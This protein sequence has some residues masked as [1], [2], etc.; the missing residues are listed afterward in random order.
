V[1]RHGGSIR[2]LDR[3]GGGTVFEVELPLPDPAGAPPS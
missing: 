2:A 3:P 1:R